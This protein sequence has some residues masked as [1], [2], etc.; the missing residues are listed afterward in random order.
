MAQLFFSEIKRK[1]KDYKKYKN[2]L[3]KNSYPSFCG[4]SWLI[5]QAFLT[6]DHY[7]PQE[8]YPELKSNPDNLI[9]CTSFC[10]DTKND[11]CPHAKNRSVYKQSKHEIFNY[12][13]EDIGRYVTIDSDGNLKYRSTKYKERFDF[14]NRV[15]RLDDPRCVAI[16]K[17]Y[18]DTLG[19]LQKLYDI[20][21]SW[22]TIDQRYLKRIKTLFYSR[23]KACSRRYIFYRLLNIEIPKHIE[24]LLINKTATQFVSQ[25]KI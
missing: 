10:N 18:L 6:V 22:K 20:L 11:Y 14:N 1:Y 23:Q 15:F 12:R 21:Q 3:E 7:K 4:Y 9:P 5:D 25:N 24:K 8:H 13:T 17:E 2:W 19:E 16:R